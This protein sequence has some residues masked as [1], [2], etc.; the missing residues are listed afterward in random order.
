MSEPPKVAEPG[1][2]EQDEDPGKV[3]SK[4]AAL[5]ACWFYKEACP[6]C[7]KMTN[8][9]LYADVPSIVCEKCGVEITGEEIL[10][11]YEARR[12]LDKYEARRSA[13]SEPSS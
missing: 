6:Y 10:H 13:A 4:Q 8:Y 9:R 12:L 3:Y 1:E 11:N 2:P 7:G 5:G